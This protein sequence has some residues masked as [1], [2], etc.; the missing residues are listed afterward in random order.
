MAT[1]DEARATVSEI[2][3]DENK[4]EVQALEDLVQDVA[5]G[6]DSGDTEGNLSAVLEP[7]D[8]DEGVFDDERQQT[9][10]WRVDVSGAVY[11]G[12]FDND[13]NEKYIE[14]ESYHH[15]MITGET[16]VEAVMKYLDVMEGFEREVRRRTR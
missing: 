1:I 9:T 8:P 12:V 11:L 14:F 3:S 6:L 2:G 7:F 16:A 15:D 13:G 5:S 4:A 10:R